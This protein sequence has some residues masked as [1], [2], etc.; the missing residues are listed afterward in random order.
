MHPAQENVLDP[1]SGLS[2]ENRAERRL[3]MMQ[4]YVDDSWEGGTA[5]IVAGYIASVPQWLRFTQL[6][7]AALD[8]EPKM[9]VFK[10]NKLRQTACRDRVESFSRI[11]EQ[12]ISGGFC[13]GIPIVPLQKVCKDLELPPIYK[14]PY[15]LAWILTLSVFRKFH[16]DTGWEHDLEVIFDRQREEKFVTEAWDKLREKQNGD[17]APIKCAPV[18]RSDE[19]MLPLQAADL[20]AWWGRKAWLQNGTFRGTQWLFPWEDRSGG[21]PYIYTEM[22][23]AGI[24][25]HFKENIIYRKE[26]SSLNISVR[27]ER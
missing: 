23:E 25:K 16:T 20:L 24:R 27:P 11:I 26:Q 6:W 5:L 9:N 12:T 10:M 3:C 4:A 17:T 15:Y 21:L 18:F 1:I 22:N 13:V 8:T 7:G 2:S 14:R 19:E